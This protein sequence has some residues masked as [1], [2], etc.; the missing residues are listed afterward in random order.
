MNELE[1]QAIAIGFK[2]CA[3]SQLRVFS[4]NIT[5]YV[6]LL[7]RVPHPPDPDN[8]NDFDRLYSK[9]RR[10]HILTNARDLMSGG[11]HDSVKVT[12]ATERCN[13]DA[14]IDFSK[15]GPSEKP[16]KAAGSNS[17]GLS[18]EENSGNGGRFHMPDYRISTCAHEIME[19]A[20]QTL[21]E[22]CAGEAK[23]ANVLFQTSRDILFLFKAVI[24]TLNEDD[25]TN[26]ART[27]MLYHNDCLYIAHHMITI[28][29]QYKQRWVPIS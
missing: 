23:C 28:G 13:L 16:A 27:C 10:Q 9:K 15:K 5:Q 4:T 29:H 7:P 3:N 20:H 21:I 11:Y 26:D 2:A 25:I 19:L 1:N 18:E 6:Y 22:A 24:P 17:A 14:S 8:L 12:G